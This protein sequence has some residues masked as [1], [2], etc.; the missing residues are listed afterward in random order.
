MSAI[1]T[2]S[3]SKIEP[4]TFYWLMAKLL[5]PSERIEGCPLVFP[6]TAF[7]DSKGRVTEIIRTDKEGLLVSIRNETKLNLQDLRRSFSII[8]RE[9][10]KESLMDAFPNS[11]LKTL[12]QIK[13]DI[14]DL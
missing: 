6:D 5:P 9:R 2:A 11:S 10:R 4:K 13:N 3:V 7:F 12:Q 14:S 8:V 1:S